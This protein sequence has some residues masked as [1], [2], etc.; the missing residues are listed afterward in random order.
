VLDLAGIAPEGGFPHPLD[1]HSLLPLLRAE[2]PLAWPDEAIVENLGEATISPIR[3]LVRGRHKLIY[4]HG[5]PDQLHD[6]EADPLEWTNLAPPDGPPAAAALAEGLK[7][8]LL[9]GWDPARADQEVRQSQH[10]RAFLKEALFAG[11]YAPW[12]YQPPGRAAEEYVR[13]GSNRQWDPDLGV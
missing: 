1:G 11:R 10:R 3:A 8:R 13:R 4:T 6:L 2:R 9:D 5:Q 12:D 7:S